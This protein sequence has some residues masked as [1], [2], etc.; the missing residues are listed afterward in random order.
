MKMKANSANE[1]GRARYKLPGPGIRIC[2]T[3]FDSYPVHQYALAGGRGA[4]KTFFTVAQNCC[5]WP[6]R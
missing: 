6:C 5:R 3:C 4:P 2:C 1:K